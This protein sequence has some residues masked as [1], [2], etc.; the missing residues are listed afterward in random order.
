MKHILF[1][2]DEPNILQGLQRMLRSMRSEWCMQFVESGPEA[3]SALAELRYD[4]IVSDMRMPGMSGAELLNLV[5]ERQP[6][7]VRMILSG[8]ADRDH[9]LRAVGATHQF[10]SK[11]CD[12]ELL[13]ATVSRACTLRDLLPSE[14]FQRVVSQ[15]RCV[16]SPPDHYQALLDGVQASDASVA[17]IAE[18]VGTDP[19]MT[20]KILQLVNSAF[21]GSP[22]QVCSARDAVALVG[23]E[24]LRDLVKG[25][26]SFCTAPDPT[27]AGFSTLQLRE[28]SLRVA[29][30]AQRFAEESGGT[31]EECAAAY[32][33]GLLHDIGKLIFGLCFPEQYREAEEGER[34]Q[35]VERAAFGTTHLEV[36]AYLLG[37]WG[38]PDVLVE[39]A[40]FH[41]DPASSPS[42][43][44]LVMTALHAADRQVRHLG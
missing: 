35:D 14:P 5:T 15:V 42:G 19:A 29:R 28:H 26:H 43:E 40:A 36:G 3:L 17:A 44:S 9:A 41:H 18:I 21:F 31:A 20:A 38:L 34:P 30:Q 7:A 37:L 22:R 11:P 24:T 4:V 39:S 10:L 6:E 25:E 27:P 16:P 32:T 8:Q 12:P 2:D 33:A 1:V 23:L 13:K